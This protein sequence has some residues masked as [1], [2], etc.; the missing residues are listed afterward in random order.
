MDE[1]EKL[2][3]T[4]DIRAIVEEKLNQGM[5]LDE[6]EDMLND[7]GEW[8]ADDVTTVITEYRNKD[9]SPIS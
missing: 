8:D 4:P 7:S 2:D 1:D 6:I 3:W 9:R 5:V